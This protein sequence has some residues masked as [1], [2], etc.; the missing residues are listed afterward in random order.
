[1]KQTIKAL[2]LITGAKIRRERIRR[3]VSQ[4]LLA[5][6]IGKTAQY[7]SLLENGDRC[8]SVA[9]YLSIAN[10]FDLNLSGLFTDMKEDIGNSVNERC[11]LELFYGCSTFEQRLMV[12]LLTAIKNVIHSDR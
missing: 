12:E 7:I 4:E 5:C 11:I 9:T 8:G 3:N 6:R 10:E 2:A 1:M